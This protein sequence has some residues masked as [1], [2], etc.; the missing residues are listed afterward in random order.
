MSN[1]NGRIE[2]TEGERREWLLG[3]LRKISRQWPIKNTARGEGRL[4]RGVYLCNCCAELFKHSEVQV[5]HIE[6]VVDPKTG[7]IDWNTYI[8]RMFVLHVKDYQVLCK[9]CHACK[10]KEENKLRAEIRRL[11]KEEEDVCSD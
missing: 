7:F 5:D 10:S 6:P 11:Q 1:L 9:E 2:L 4:E 3:W 8:D